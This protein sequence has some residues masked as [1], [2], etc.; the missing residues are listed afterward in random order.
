M[1]GLELSTVQYGIAPPAYTVNAISDPHAARPVR[2]ILHA[3][4][5]LLLVYQGGLGKVRTGF[6]SGN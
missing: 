1:L 6:H 4:L 3:P 2:R 5:L